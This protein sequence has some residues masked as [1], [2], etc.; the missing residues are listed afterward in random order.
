MVGR[1]VR[2]LLGR[3]GLRYALVNS[4]LSPETAE[5]GKKGGK[6]GRREIYKERN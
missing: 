2:G 5:G 1:E 3:P 6:E 4:N